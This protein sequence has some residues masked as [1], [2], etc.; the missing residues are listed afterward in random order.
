MPAF[1]WNHIPV[2]MHVCNATGP[3]NDTTLKYFTKYPIITFEKAQGINSTQFP[4]TSLYA[5]NKIIESCKQIKSIKPDIICIFYYNSIIDWPYYRLHD[6]FIENPSMWLRDNNNDIVLIGGDKSFPQPS[7]GMLVPDYR[8]EI[9]QTFWASECYNITSA[10]YGIVDGC[11]ND[12]SQKN[13]FEGYN[14]TKQQLNDFEIGHNASIKSIQYELNKTNASV[15]ITEKG[16]VVDGIIAT[17]IPFFSANEQSI[18]ELL[19]FSEKGILVEAHVAETDCTDITDTLSAFL[20]GANKYS[21]YACSTGWIWPDNWNVWY[22]QFDKPLGEP[23]ADAVKNGNV[24]SR[25]F[26]FGTNVTF[27]TQTNKGTI[28][29]GSFLYVL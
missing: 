1:S 17:M 9:V 12:K 10:N 4:Y 14:F 15:V 5:E 24:Y 3:W 20:I 11:F 6:K 26:V 25:S 21:Y 2:F 28:E 13:S 27:N 22:P 8:Q 29:W 18:K 7:Q 16:Y 19:S 23:L